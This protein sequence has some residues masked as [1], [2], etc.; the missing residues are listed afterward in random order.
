MKE[1]SRGEV[2]AAP[3][4]IRSQA[5]ATN[6][7][8]GG[9]LPVEIVPLPVGHRHCRVAQLP[10]LPA[11][12]QRAPGRFPPAHTLPRPNHTNVRKASHTMFPVSCI[13]NTRVVLRPGESVL[14][15][16]PPRPIPCLP[17]TPRPTRSLSRSTLPECRFCSP[18]LD[19]RT[20]PQPSTSGT[21]AAAASPRRPAHSNNLGSATC[22]HIARPTH[23]GAEKRRSPT[24]R[25]E[26]VGASSAKPCRKASPCSSFTFCML[27]GNCPC[28]SGWRS[29]KSSH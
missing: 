19:L 24:W 23:N 14:V 16:P 10:K 9:H 2:N 29:Q 4:Q 22:K 28:H 21:T 20:P 7:G 12:Q 25:R 27:V 15:H 5:A 6:R 17:P 13:S 11:L 26:V 8:Q 3:T 1:Q 18:T